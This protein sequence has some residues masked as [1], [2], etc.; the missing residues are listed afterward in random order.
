[1]T[2]QY[3]NVQIVMMDIKTVKHFGCKKIGRFQQR[4]WTVIGPY[5][6]EI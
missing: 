3:R 6:P 5:M 2:E 4:F 1:M